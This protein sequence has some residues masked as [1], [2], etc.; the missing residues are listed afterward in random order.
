MPSARKYHDYG[1]V[2]IE[3]LHW[4]P[5]SHPFESVRIRAM[6]CNCPVKDVIALFEVLG[7]EDNVIGHAKPASLSI[8]PGL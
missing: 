1:R 7:E 4:W 3:S 8:I 2:L 6:W 5:R